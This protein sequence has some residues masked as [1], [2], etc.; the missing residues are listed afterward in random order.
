MVNSHSAWNHENSRYS[1]V[2]ARGSLL[3]IESRER[4]WYGDWKQSSH[5][6]FKKTLNMSFCMMH[7]NHIRRWLATKR[8]NECPIVNFFYNHVICFEQSIS[9]IYSK[10]AILTT[11]RP[12]LVKAVFLNRLFP[13]YT[14]FVVLLILTHNW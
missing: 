1:A 4:I 5:Y 12:M 11:V 13:Y 14:H 9:N 2:H 3:N 10:I 7:W 6:L 8:H